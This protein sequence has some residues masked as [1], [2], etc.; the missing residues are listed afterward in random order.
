MAQ[1]VYK[2]WTVKFKEAWY[3]LSKDE[4]NS[5]FA[6]VTATLEKVGAKIVVACDASWSSEQWPFFGIEEYPDI[7]AVQAHAQLLNEMQWFRYVEST[8]ALGTALEIEHVL[9]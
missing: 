9:G 8:T 5:L 3:Q 4:R 1:P 7:E 2:L 6:Q